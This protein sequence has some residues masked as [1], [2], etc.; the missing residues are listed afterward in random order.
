MPKVTK[1]QPVRRQVTPC[2]M[3]QRN[4]QQLSRCFDCVRNSDEC[5][6]QGAFT[7]LVNIQSSSNAPFYREALV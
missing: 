6:F 3:K 2:Q 5:R 7:L 1:K 4:G